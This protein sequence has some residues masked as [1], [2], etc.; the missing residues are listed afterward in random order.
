MTN[1]QPLTWLGHLGHAPGISIQARGLAS[2]LV[3]FA[4]D[5]WISEK[6]LAILLGKTSRRIQDYLGE[7]TG[8]GWLTLLSLGSNFGVQAKASTYHLAI[9]E[10]AAHVW[11]TGELVLV[12][13]CSEHRKDSSGDTDHRKDLTGTPETFDGTPET[14]DR[15]TGKKLPPNRDKNRDKEQV[16]EAPSPSGSDAREKP[17]PITLAEYRRRTALADAPVGASALA[18]TRDTGLASGQVPPVQGLDKDI[19]VPVPKSRV[20]K[21]KTKAQQEHEQQELTLE[22]SAKYFADILAGK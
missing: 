3:K 18:D 2:E 10:H 13:S 22:E 6:N 16:Y 8:S 9:P 14:F 1:I 21:F 4:P 11:V 17:K 5:I 7:L 15:I 12:P 19:P 20:P